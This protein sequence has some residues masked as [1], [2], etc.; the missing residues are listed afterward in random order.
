MFISSEHSSYDT[1]CFAVLEILWSYF[2]H[3]SAE[4]TEQYETK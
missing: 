2:H 3:K 1:Y 4:Q